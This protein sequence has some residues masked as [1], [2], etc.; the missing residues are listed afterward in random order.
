MTRPRASA[1][2][3]ENPEKIS[4]KSKRFVQQTLLRWLTREDWVRRAV[5][6]ALLALP[7]RVTCLGQEA[8]QAIEVVCT[9]A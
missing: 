6:F 7:G 9:E 4:I 8:R 2:C 3:G 1:H 5:S